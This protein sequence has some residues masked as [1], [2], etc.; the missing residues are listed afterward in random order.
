[1]ITDELTSDQAHI[2]RLE[3]RLERSE[4][5]REA[6]LAAR[7]KADAAVDRAANDPHG[8]EG[9]YHGLDIYDSYWPDYAMIPINL[10]IGEMKAIREAIK[11]AEAED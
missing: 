4:R 6:L 7:K 9:S 3:I 10:T 1:M 2:E 5:D 8:D 11:Q